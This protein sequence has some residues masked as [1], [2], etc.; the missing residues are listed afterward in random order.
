MTRPGENPPREDPASRFTGFPVPDGPFN[1]AEA[2]AEALQ[3]FGL[4]PRPDPRLQPQLRL[5]WDRV[6]GQPLLLQPFVFDRVLNEQA[7]YTIQ[8]RLLKAPA[9]ATSRIEASSNWS[10]AYITANRGRRFG[11]VWGTFTIPDNLK[12]PPAPLQGDPGKDYRAACWIGLDGQRRYFDAS[13]PQIG[14]TS[15]LEPGGTR[16]AEAWVQWYA[17]EEQTLQLVTLPLAVSP[18]QMVACVLTVTGP[19]EVV[20]SMTNLSSGAKTMPVKFNPP[21]AALPDGGFARPTVSGAT[22]EWVVERSRDVN[23]SRLDNFPDYGQV[24][25]HNCLAVE[26]DTPSGPPAS[27]LPMTLKGARAIRMFDML[28]GPARTQYISMPRKVEATTL[29]MRY[30]GF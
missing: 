3:R 5:A 25:F 30:G 6:F 9:P 26:G 28:Q 10:S 17:R 23:T 21:F 24:S 2:T 11:Q 14:A 16:R 22:A 1:P 20:C 15:I 18:G 4:P 12:V 29:R 19:Q 13:L 8:P 7:R 27:G